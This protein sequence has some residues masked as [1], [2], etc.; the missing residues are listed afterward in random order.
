MEND[1]FVVLSDIH[2]TQKSAQ[3]IIVRLNEFKKSIELIKIVE[4]YKNIVIL[5][6]GDIAFSGNKSEYKLIIDYFRELSLISKVIFCAGNHDHDFSIY[7]GKLIRDAL[8]KLP[9]E[10]YDDSIIEQVIEG[11]KCYYEFESKICN[12]E[13]AKKTLLSKMY[14]FE[15]DVRKYSIQSLNTAWCSTLNETGGSLKFP[16]NQIIENNDEAYLR[17][18][19]FHHP[20]SWLEPNNSKDL[21]NTLRG[22][23]EIIITGHEH[24]SDSFKVQ[25]NSSLTLMI[26][27]TTFFDEAVG[28]NGFITFSPDNQ[29]IHIIK[30]IWSN[31]KFVE[32]DRKKKSDIVKQASLS[33]QGFDLNISYCDYLNDIGSGFSHSDVA[34]ILIDDVYVPPNLKNLSEENSTIKRESSVELLKKGF[35]KIVLVGEECSGKTTLL[36]K[37]YLETI[38]NSKIPILLDGYYIK[39]PLTFVNKKLEDE[40]KKQYNNLDIGKLFSSN[41]EKVLLIDNFD[42]IHGDES[43]KKIFLDKLSDIFNS[44]I[45]T[46]SDNY[47][48]SESQIKG[49]SI[50]EGAFIKFE[51]LKFGY[52]LRYELINKWN[53]LKPS[54][55]DSNKQLLLDNDEASKRINRI[56]GKSYI[57][58]TPFFLLTMLQSIDS[59]HSVDM[60]TSSYGYYYQYLITSSLGAASVKKDNLDEIFN[61]IKELSFYFHQNK[62][63]EIHLNELWKYNNSFCES[64]CLKIDFQ[65]R[66]NLLVQA[67]ILNCGNEYY[68]FKYPYIYY[69]FIAKY[70]SE[71]INDEPSKT[72][73]DKLVLTLDKRFSMSIL[74]FLTHHSKDKSI[75]DRIVNHAKSLFS[76]FDPTSLG[77]TS[78]F[79]DKIIVDL[80]VIHYQEIDHHQ[81]RRDI[82]DEK[83]NKDEDE[84]DKNEQRSD[85][86]TESDSFKQERSLSHLMNEFNLTFKT[87]D[88]LGQLTRN[89]YGSLKV[90]QKEGLLSEAIKTPL[91]ALE[92]IFSILR[93]DPDKVLSMIELK[94]KEKM[95]KKGLCSPVESKNIAREI[96]FNLMSIIT[97]NIIK[98][99]SNSIGNHHL[100]PVIENITT[101]FDTNAIKLI[102]LSTKLDLGTHPSISDLK[103]LMISLNSSSIS[104]VILQSMIVNYLYMFEL[105]DSEIK[106]ICHAVMINYTPIAK[107]M[108]YEKLINSK[109]SSTI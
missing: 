98:K 6:S 108:G 57:P 100:I 104:K 66:F 69:F 2:V 56:I 55:K 73:I 4:E 13:I 99:I 72:I 63:K 17:I 30:Y 9:I 106:K 47:D 40:V 78:F 102:D 38:N 94:I 12:I 52:G 10:N 50:Y 85:L 67:K 91:R 92:S 31:D 43:A 84:N 75:L 34:N 95:L 8:L 11:Q 16:L 89:Y 90:E 77:K 44:I 79:I 7:Q 32:L 87:L 74:M 109:Q 65:A 60:N 42:L 97:Y 61:Y 45:I 41:S 26:E 70:L 39:K 76:K 24:I 93:E 22:K 23:N 14:L 101:K 107:Q 81:Y 20:L 18:V 25:T 88:L 28:E 33:S 19:F 71:N 36:K 53:K 1:L 3:K 59:G 105:K 51:I 37:L 29:D 82:E 62:K 103:Y 35:K 68:S 48:L 15:S 64:Y 86:D 58:S 21:R 5:V 27:S 80:P 49:N 46:V 83:D 54:C 96:L